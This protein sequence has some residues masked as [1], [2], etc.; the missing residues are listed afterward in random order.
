MRI[1]HYKDW[2]LLIS[3]NLSD[4]EARSLFDTIS[5]KTYNVKETLKQNQ[6]SNVFRIIHEGQSLVLKVPVEKNK[7][8]WIRFLTW[9][10]QG[11]A[12]KN[13][14]GMEKLWSKGIKT[15]QHV[16]AA[17]KRKNGM[18]VDSWLTYEYLD[19]ESCLEQPQLFPQ[20][21]ST[22]TSMHN[23]NLLHGDPQVRNF[24]AADSDIYIID[25]NP[26]SASNSFSRAYEWAY[27]RRSSPDI[28]NHFG[29]IQNWWLYKFARW[30]DIT[31]RKLKRFKRKLF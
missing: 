20:V 31:E 24:I 29:E 28:E 9:F 3:D 25:S 30:Y 17:E 21:V 6:R 18:V 14:M 16:L 15:T 26:K 22:L 2:R 7:G 23:N 4:D 13:L 19:G 27:L 1:I 5:D 12:F 8:K 11:E 10:R